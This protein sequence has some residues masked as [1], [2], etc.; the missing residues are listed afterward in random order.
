VL[1]FVDLLKAAPLTLQARRRRPLTLLSSFAKK[2]KAQKQ[3]REQWS[4]QDDRDRDTQWVDHP[5]VA[6]TLA[7]LQALC[8]LELAGA[9]VTTAAS[10]RM[11]QETHH[12]PHQ[13]Q[14]QQGHAQPPTA[15]TEFGKAGMSGKGQQQQQQ[16]QQ[17]LAGISSS[18]GR[19]VPVAKVYLKGHSTH[20]AIV[21]D[22]PSRR[23]RV[24]GKPGSA[25]RARAEKTLSDEAHLAVCKKAL[26]AGTAN[27]VQLAF[28]HSEQGNAATRAA[29][30]VKHFNLSNWEV[31]LGLL[32]RF[33]GAG[34]DATA[35]AGGDNGD[36][37]V[38]DAAGEVMG[39]S[40]NLQRQNSNPRWRNV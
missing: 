12:H 34:F 6:S 1:A 27:V 8:A 20:V 2:W 35:D 31:V 23:L 7:L 40:R 9:S 36:G 24:G 14:R 11:R 37:E 29:A 18:A 25:R 10:Q 3:Q 21:V 19:D 22:K 28:V 33:A 13:Q 38:G 17:R 4:K 30:G 15:A 32:G 26:A 16:Q 5:C 39:S